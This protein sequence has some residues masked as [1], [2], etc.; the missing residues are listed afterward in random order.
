MV[1]ITEAMYT[2]LSPLL[3][4]LARRAAPSMGEDWEDVYSELLE[5]L[6][7]CC[8]KYTTKE[9]D[10]LKRLIVQSCK[11]RIYELRSRNL[12]T[13][14]SA[15][16]T[17]LSIEAGEQDEDGDGMHCAY[18][19]IQPATQDFYMIEV[20][21]CMGTDAR[22]MMEEILNPSPRALFHFSLQEHRKRSTALRGMEC[23][24][25]NA[26]VMASAMGWS[27]ARTKLAWQEIYSVLRQG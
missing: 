16:Q 13:H 26:E 20:L 24:H 1:D 7:K 3:Q 10:E 5:E 19:N 8:R 22:T 25:I 6:V 9:G 18:R 15:E 27:Y 4:N 21:D 23:H 2:D 11:N 17:M 12:T 14:R